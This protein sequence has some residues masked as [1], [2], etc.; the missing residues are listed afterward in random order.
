MTVVKDRSVCD[1]SCG[2]TCDKG[3]SAGKKSG[4]PVR[5]LG[6]RF[7][8]RGP[9]D[10]WELTKELTELSKRLTAD[11][12]WQGAQLHDVRTRTT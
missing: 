9:L 4:W 6:G 3:G 2:C 1:E 8:N 7:L 11:P 10:G 12:G 5:R